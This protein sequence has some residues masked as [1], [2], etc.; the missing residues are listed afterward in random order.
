MSIIKKDSFLFHLPKEVKTKQLLTIDAIRFCCELIDHSYRNLIRNAKS[1]S[2]NHEIVGKRKINLIPLF[3]YAWAII[4]HTQRL[5]KLYKSLPTANCHELIEP[6]EFVRDFRHTFQHI[7]ERIEQG[8]YNQEIPFFGV[9][10]W[11]SYCDLEMHNYTTFAISG[12]F[13]SRGEFEMKI[14]KGEVIKENVIKRI[15]LQTI[16]NEGDRKNPIYRKKEIYLDELI[17][18]IKHFISKY[19][20]SLLLQTERFKLQPVENWDSLRDIVVKSPL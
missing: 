3:N 19:E 11:E 7:D 12:L 1:I 4:D 14:I 15:K 13:I 16:I 20:E 6:L 18:S 8:L 9:I 17:T 2:G 10:S 5:V